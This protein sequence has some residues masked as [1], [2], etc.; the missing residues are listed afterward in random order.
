MGAGI[1]RWWRE[2]EPS[3][4]FGPRE[5]PEFH[6]DAIEIKLRHWSGKVV[7]PTPW[8]FCA[9]CATISCA[10]FHCC[11]KNPRYTWDLRGLTSL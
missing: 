4:D 5:I 2:T 8:W 1:Q 9:D 6:D 7:H 3:V 11:P 10:D